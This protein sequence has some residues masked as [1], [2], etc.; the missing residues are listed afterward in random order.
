MMNL[1]DKEK[2]WLSLSVAF[3]A[4]WLIALIMGLIF[5]SPLL[6]LTFGLPLSIWTLKYGYQKQGEQEES[7]GGFLGQFTG[8][9]IPPG[10]SW[11][12]PKPFG[13]ALQKKSTAKQ[14]LDR[15][16]KTGNQFVQVKTQDGAVVETGLVKTW[17]VSNTLKAARFS[18]ADLEKQVDSLADR[19][20][21]LFA[22]YFD[23]DEAQDGKP[24]TALANKKMEFSSFLK[25]DERIP[26]PKKITDPTQPEFIPND[27]KIKAEDIGITIDNVDVTDVNE[28]KEVQEARN[29]AA[30]E[31]GQADGERLDINS[32]R[33]RVLELMWGT[34]DPK[35][36]KKK[37]RASEAPLVSEADALRAV[38][39][40]RGDLEDINVSGGAGDFS[41]GAAITTRKKRGS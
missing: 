19:G 27:T 3:T 39:S 16:A 37:K 29:K 26:N 7:V 6:I 18:D 4:P 15:S 12:I 5:M 8:W 11:W 34:S 23:S 13:Q 33:N 40:A 38:R 30:A 9:V 31:H 41:K 10:S 28:P 35:L 21:R 20:V 36:I 17:H 2:L 24:E 32:V 1:T 22:L 25:G 14:T